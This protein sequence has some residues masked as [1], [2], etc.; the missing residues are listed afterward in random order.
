MKR[1]Q[2]GSSQALCSFCVPE[3]PEVELKVLAFVLLDLALGQ[4]FLCISHSLL[5]WKCLLCGI[6]YWEHAIC[7]LILITLQLGIRSESHRRFELGFL[8]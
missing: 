5:E 3:M 2:G 1:P 6:V 7:F 4:C 8:E